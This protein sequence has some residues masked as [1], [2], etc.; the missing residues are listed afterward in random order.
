MSLHVIFYNDSYCVYF[1]FTYV[2]FSRVFIESICVRDFKL[3]VLL[4]LLKMTY[5]YV[6]S[7]FIYLTL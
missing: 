4:C 3:A 1:Y 7:I 2:V 6:I 5:F